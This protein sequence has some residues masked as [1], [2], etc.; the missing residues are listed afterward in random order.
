[1]PEP[2]NPQSLNRFSYSLSNPLKYTDSSGHCIDGITTWICVLTAAYVGGRAA[3]EAASLFI[4]G[5]DRSTRDTIGGALVT[6]V[7]DIIS[8]QSARQG[9][10]PNLVA[11][12]L[13]HESAA[14]ER[15]LFT[16]LPRSEPGLLANAAE[17]ADLLRQG[18]TASIGP[19]Q[20]QLRR[21]RELEQLGYVTA[22]AN[23]LGRVQALL[24]RDSSVE[25]AAGMLHYISDQF[26]TYQGFSDLSQENQQRLI[27][28]GY[29]WGWTPEFLDQLTKRG[30]LGAIEYFAYDDQTLDEYL[31][32][33]AGQ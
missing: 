23:D 6:D 1:V 10:D 8:T 16:F 17:I 5:S 21:A 29:N 31:R 20:I 22:R 2:G 24:G 19:A 9:V 14:V 15:R 25:Y 32:W 28:I 27:L 33:I 26:Q 12:V 30:L 11:A 13:R 18:D 3:Y 7:S 4:P